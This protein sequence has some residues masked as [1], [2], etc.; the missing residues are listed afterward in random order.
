MDAHAWLGKD[1]NIS[2]NRA[3][4]NGQKVGEVF[5]RH[6][7]TLIERFFNDAAGPHL[8]Q[9]LWTVTAA[10]LLA[11]SAIVDGHGKCS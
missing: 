8:P 6:D 11:L 3:D 7:A 2:L 9:R 4:I 5:L 1:L 10:H